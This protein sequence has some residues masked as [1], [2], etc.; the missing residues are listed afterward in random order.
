MT[1][2]ELVSK[3]SKVYDGAQ[4]PEISEHLAIQFDIAEEAAG[5][6]N[7]EVAGGEVSVNPYDYMD[8]DVLVSSTAEVV[9]DVLNGKKSI[10]QA[11][12]EGT[13]RVEGDA[14][15]VELLKKAETKRAKKTAPA[16]KAAAKKSSSTK[17][18]TAK[19]TAKTADKKTATKKT[20]AKKAA[21]KPA[22]A[23]KA[24]DNKTTDK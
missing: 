8:R 24:A 12:E 23:K 6:F 14:Q 15:K 10:F 11:I 13:L 22:A 7:I 16:K 19:A 5:A 9:I 21:A 2:E 3:I 20:A 1:Y 18:T 4:A 17:K